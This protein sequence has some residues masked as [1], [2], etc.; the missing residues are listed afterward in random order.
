MVYVLFSGLLWALLAFYLYTTWRFILGWR[1]V[2]RFVAEPINKPVKVSVIIAAR[3]EEDK[4]AI[5]LKAI[6]AQNYPVDYLEVIVIDDH[7]EDTTSQVVNGFDSV[8][9][10]KLNEGNT[11]NSYKKKAI[12]EGIKIASG[13][14]IITTD[15]DCEMG[16]DWISTIVSYYQK[17]GNK[18]ISGPVAFTGERNWF[19]NIQTIEFLYLNLTGAASI[20]QG[21]PFSC[22]GANL[23]YT[24]EVF[25]EVGGFTGIDHL[26]SGDD[27]LLMHK[28]HQQYPGTIGYLK[29]RDAIVYTDAKPTLQ[30]FIQQRKRWASKSIKYQSSFIVTTVVGIWAFNLVLILALLSLGID[31]AILPVLG[32]VLALKFV[33]DLI[34]MFQAT[35]FFKR[36]ELLKYALLVQYLYMLYVAFIGI[37]GNTG[38]YYWKG[39]HVN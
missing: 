31:T 29:N 35:S 36:M 23:T 27:E 5:C 18:M 8:M 20:G 2:P 7:S 3:N 12:T 4:I 37:Y 13:E 9:L 28:V 39:R 19:E 25:N 22:N 21:I 34:I 33:A 16:K 38:K 17:T 6:L 26:A 10:L 32:W 1:K 11:L 15:A 24:K 14:L 30:K